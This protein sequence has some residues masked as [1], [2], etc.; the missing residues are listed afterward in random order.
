MRSAI[1]RTVDRWLE[2]VGSAF[3][4]EIESPDGT[5]LLVGLDPIWQ[6]AQVITASADADLHDLVTV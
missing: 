3:V 4:M 6:G 2:R 1:A 5:C